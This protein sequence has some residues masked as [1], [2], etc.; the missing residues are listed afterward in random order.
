[1][2]KLTLGSLHLVMKVKYS[3]PNFLTSNKPACVPTS[4]SLT[5]SV[6]LQTVPPQALAILLLSDLRTLLMAVIPAFKRKCWAR[7]A[8]LKLI[9]FENYIFQGR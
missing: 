1:M 2:L 9:Y 6:L 3:S 8:Y 4:L 5:S 7:S